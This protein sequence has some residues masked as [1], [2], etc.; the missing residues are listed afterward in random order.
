MHARKQARETSA[1]FETNAANDMVC[2]GKSQYCFKRVLVDWSC[3]DTGVE[4]HRKLGLFCSTA[5]D[6]FA[7]DVVLVVILTS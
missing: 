7:R 3:D 4:I 1:L 2:A 6:P 5:S